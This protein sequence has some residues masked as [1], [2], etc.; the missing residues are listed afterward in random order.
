MRLIDLNIRNRSST[1]TDVILSNRSNK[2][3]N[4]EKFQRRTQSVIL[5]PK[6]SFKG[7]SPR[8]KALS[9]K[10]EKNLL[11]KGLTLEETDLAVQKMTTQEKNQLTGID[12][13]LDEQDKG[14][15]TLSPTVS[16]QMSKTKLAIDEIN[17]GVSELI[18]MRLQLKQD[19]EKEP[20]ILL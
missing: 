11:V 3:S 8:H 14:G 16:A 9:P 7:I 5:G 19:F 12:E 4:K 13:I 2:D 17:H 20:E 15:V 6:M 18:D 1:N 10:N